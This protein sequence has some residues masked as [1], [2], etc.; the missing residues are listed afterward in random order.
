MNDQQP[1]TS[2]I[3]ISENRAIADT[4]FQEL[5]EVPPEVEWFNNISNPRTRRAY[6]I[7]VTDFFGF[8]GIMELIEVRQVS[9]S[10]V[11]A[12]R[13]LLSNNGA[14]PATVRRKLSA[15][16]SMFD[17][18]CDKNAVETN[19]VDGVKRP[20][21]DN[22]E[23]K[24]PAISDAQAKKLLNAPDP[25]T[26]KG[27]RD[28]A[29]LATFLYHG[30]RV[31]ELCSLKVG[32]IQERR[33]V[34]H[35]RIHGKRSKLRYVPVHPEALTRIHDYFAVGGHI[36][37][38]PSPLFR[39]VRNLI[40]H[41]LDKHLNTSSVFRLVRKYGVQVGIATSPFSP[42]SL[43]AT[44]ATNALEHSA[45]IAKVQQWLGHANVSTTR[46]YDRRKS[47]PEESPTY[48]VKY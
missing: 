20:M 3:P 40:T 36:D 19:P 46:L 44:S 10:H 45:D 34:V 14:S 1:P 16:A 47:R 24:T 33:G 18:L 13:D 28:R 5:A 17:Y 39:P 30:L 41:T 4:R 11:I 22:N 38:K 42:H 29:I 7:D 12:W 25:K 43:R 8:I 6:R 37:E 31:Q 23:G 15:V 9:R 48:Q 26:K 21:A 32:D 2:I 27:I 35:F